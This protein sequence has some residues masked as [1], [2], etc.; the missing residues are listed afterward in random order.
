MFQWIDQ[1]HLH[2][3]NFR[4]VVMIIIIIIRLT[5]QFHLKWVAQGSID[6]NLNTKLHGICSW[7]IWV[8]LFQDSFLTCV[9]VCVSTSVPSTCCCRWRM[10]SKSAYAANGALSCFCTFV[11]FSVGSSTGISYVVCCAFS[12]LQYCTC[13]ASK[14]SLMNLCSHK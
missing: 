10:H 11:N 7:Y 1:P 2:H 9:C 3:N 14:S 8:L 13:D 4:I 5:C 12:T 6:V